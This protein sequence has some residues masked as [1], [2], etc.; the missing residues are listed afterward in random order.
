MKIFSDILFTLSARSIRLNMLR[1]ILSALGITIGVIA[2]SAMGMLG[3]NMTSVVSAQMS[4]MANTMTV[5]AY[6]GGSSGGWS[7]P[8]MGGGS[9]DDSYI[10][11]K[12]YDDIYQIASRYGTV[13]PYY[14]ESDTIYTKNDQ[15][16]RA[17]IYGLD[18]EDMQTVLTVANGTLPRSENDVVVGTTLAGRQD[19]EVG[20]R[21]KIG[22]EDEQ[23]IKVRV[24]GILAETGLSSSLR[25]DNAIVMTDDLYTSFYGGEGKYDQVTILLDNVND[26]AVVKNALTSKL[27]KRED[28][29]SVSDSSSMASRVTESISTMVTFMQAI[30]AISLLVAAVSIFN[31]MM[32]SVTERIS[33]IGILRSI[34]TQKDEVMRMFVYEALII[35][36]IGSTA[37]VILSFIAGYIVV[38]LLIGSTAYFFGWNSMMYLPIG[39]VIGVSICIV[40][41]L[42]P[43]WRAANMDPVEAL[44]AE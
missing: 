29:I 20:S 35:G 41:G 17:T 43:A 44:R 4:S 6:T 12:Q 5:T 31:V 34:G 30:A 3:A 14:S 42:Y 27:N 19:L 16:G 23:Q 8:G 11:D 15:K 33:E 22:D 21:F 2:I 28:V 18:K 38:A 7:P 26:S 9:N 1:S 13:Y 24:S 10:T 40:T 39:M 37:G 25:T 32:M 36:L